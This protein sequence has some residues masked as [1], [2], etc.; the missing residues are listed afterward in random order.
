[1]SDEKMSMEDEFKIWS[2]QTHDNGEKLKE[3]E[4]NVKRHQTRLEEHR[5]EIDF[6]MKKNGDLEDEIAELKESEEAFY[7]DLRS[8]FLYIERLE[9]NNQEVL[10]EFLEDLGSL[11][12]KDIHYPTIKS[13]IIYHIKKWQ[14][15]LKK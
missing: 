12:H 14:G 2:K 6:N 4:K 15:R 1:M 8:R 9:L 10:R 5:S 7:N 3:L 11:G 13:Q